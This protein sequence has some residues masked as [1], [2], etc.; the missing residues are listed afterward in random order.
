M[1]VNAVELSRSLHWIG[2]LF[3]QRIYYCT[4][5]GL[6]GYSLKSKQSLCT[7]LPSPTVRLLTSQ[8]TSVI[9]IC[10]SHFKTTSHFLFCITCLFHSCHLGVELSGTEP[11]FR[12]LTRSPS[13]N[14]A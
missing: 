3:K 9:I 1:S 4:W 11:P 8:T 13:S 2:L 5:S 7:T 6:L 14:P 12:I 10:P